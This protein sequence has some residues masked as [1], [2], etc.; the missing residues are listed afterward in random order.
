M[1]ILY[2]FHYGDTPKS[3]YYDERKEKGK[4]I[5]GDGGTNIHVHLLK[6][7]T[8]KREKVFFSTFENNYQLN[9][10]FSKDKNVTF[11]NFDTLEGFTGIKNF[12]LENLY[13]LLV[14][15]LILLCKRKN[16]E[17][18]VSATDF[19]PD[20][21]PA[22]LLKMKMPKTK[23][24]ASYFLDAPSP[25]NKNNPY[26]GEPWRY[27][28]GLTYWLTQRA[29]LFLINLAADSVLVT[30]EPDIKLFRKSKE[31]VVVQGGVDIEAAKKYLS[32][33]KKTTKKYE[34]CFLGRFHYQKGVLELIDI[35]NL[36]C[37]KKPTAKLAMIGNG[38][39]E[40]E[41]K[42]KIMDYGLEKNINLFGFVT[43]T[44]KY[45]IFKE[46]KIIV[47]PATYDSGG[48]ATAEGMVW[49]LP[50]I[51]FNLESLKTYYPQG[52]LK[53][54]QKNLKRFSSSILRLLQD[55][56]LY[57][58]TASQA[59]DLI[60]N[61]WDWKIRAAQICREAFYG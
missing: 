43:G 52:M 40:L 54:P 24:T 11:L 50:A 41:V 17:V 19:L 49:G 12:F 58:K 60:L 28:R 36:V 35:W 32:S 9:A 21:L 3:F 7:L 6:Y 27:L 33:K 30:S 29:S 13:R 15:S 25:F 42:R 16:Y 44:E 4:K 20:V 38:P 47:H 31:V 46:S 39:L 18:I 51:G 26:R 48:M 53:V 2:L 23:W 8:Q 59:I 5:I 1:K 57:R 22:F 45:Q 10:F 37:Q 14:P 34:A 55:K 56:K 61:V